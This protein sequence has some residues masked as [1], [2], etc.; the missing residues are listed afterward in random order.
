MAVPLSEVLC[1]LSVSQPPCMHLFSPVCEDPKPRG[2]LV[3]VRAGHAVL[4]GLR[5]DC[6]GPGPGIQRQPRRQRGRAPGHVARQ[7]GLWSA[8]R[9]SLLSCG[10]ALVGGRHGVAATGVFL[11]VALLHSA[12]VWC[13]SD[14]RAPA[15]NKHFLKH[16]APLP[17]LQPRQYGV[18]LWIHTGT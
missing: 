15:L 16:M 2:D 5:H 3:G 13:C 11:L 17:A 8:Q 1:S 18:R 9:V 7:Q 6:P 14:P 4:P 10:V 12:L